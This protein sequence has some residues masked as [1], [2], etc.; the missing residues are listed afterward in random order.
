MELCEL[1]RCM[2][3]LARWRL[4]NL[5]LTLLLHKSIVLDKVATTSPINNV[6][7]WK[8]YCKTIQTNF[9]LW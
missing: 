3:A 9:E 6:N 4:V 5:R 8:L 2:V 1:L 7:I